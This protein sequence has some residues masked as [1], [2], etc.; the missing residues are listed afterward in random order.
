MFFQRIDG[1]SPSAPPAKPSFL[2]GIPES[3]WWS[4]HSSHA[5]VT[6]DCLVTCE[7]F[8]IRTVETIWGSPQY[9]RW[10]LDFRVI[11]VYYSILSEWWGISELSRLLGIIQS[12]S[13]EQKNYIPR[14]AADNF[15]NRTI[16]PDFGSIPVASSA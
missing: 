3:S 12:Y 4:S 10:C 8:L 5:Q 13:L 15:E 2:Q 9:P 14:S 11:P 16:S 6:S 7:A 1:S